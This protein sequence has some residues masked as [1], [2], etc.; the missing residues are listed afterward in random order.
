M[1]KCPQKITLGEMRAAGVRGVLIYCA[2]YKCSHWIRMNAD[3]RP[4]D[5][6]L[7]DLE[8]KFTC[9]KHPAKTHKGLAR[10]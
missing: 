10:F 7:S 5:I 2:D 3:Q 9:T 6:R 4:N 1:N 8:D